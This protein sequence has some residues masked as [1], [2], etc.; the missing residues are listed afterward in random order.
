M[1]FSAMCEWD[2]NVCF[3][4]EYVFIALIHVRNVGF[5]FLLHDLTSDNFLFLYWLLQYKQMIR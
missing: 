1:F 3:C 5:F 2:V 4:A